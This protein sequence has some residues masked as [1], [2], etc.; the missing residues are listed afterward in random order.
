M[1]PYLV[2]ME[3]MELQTLIT[4]IAVVLAAAFIL[5]TFTRQFTARGQKG[6]ASCGQRGARQEGQLI[7]IESIGEER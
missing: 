1:C 6:C 3:N 7:S 5:R 2:N 4:T